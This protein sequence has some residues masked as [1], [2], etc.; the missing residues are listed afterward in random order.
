MFPKTP[1]LRFEISYYVATS[2]SSISENVC[3]ASSISRVWESSPSLSS[4]S[5]ILR[6]SVYC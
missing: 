1:V 2:L 4:I 5:F 3:S 6:K